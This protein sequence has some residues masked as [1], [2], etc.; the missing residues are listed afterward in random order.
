MGGVGSRSTRP[1]GAADLTALHVG[2]MRVSVPRP[3]PA[4]PSAE[5]ALP[6]R[7]RGSAPSPACESGASA[8]SSADARAAQPHHRRRRHPRRQRRTTRA[9]PPASPSRCSTSRSSPRASRSAARRRTADTAC[10][11]PRRR[12]S[13]V[14]ARRALR[15]L[16]PSGSTRRPA[17]RRSCASAASA[18]RSAA[19]T[20]RSSAGDLLRPPQW[21]RQG[22]G[23]YPP[24]RELGYEAAAQA[25]AGLRARHRGGGH[26]ATTVDLKGGLGSASTVTPSGYA[27]GALVVVNAIGSAVD[28]RRPAFL[29]RPLRGGRRVRRARAGRGGHAGDAP[30]RLEGRP[31]AGHDH[32]ARRHRCRAYQGHGEAPRDRRPSRPRQGAEPLARALRRRH[33]LLGGDRAQAAARSGPHVIEICAAATNCMARAIARGV[34]EATALPFPGSLPAWR[35]RFGGGRGRE[36]S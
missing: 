30:H 25:S 5:S 29:G 3:P 32:R 4:R 6:A 16:R 1:D 17:C 13:G 22:W 12:S 11:S 18:S 14:N 9:S 10:S 36:R 2:G 31:A 21:R 33:D 19:C 28:R 23:R 8:L 26:G 7:G 20:C 15:R 35:D 24:Y 27:I 34:Y